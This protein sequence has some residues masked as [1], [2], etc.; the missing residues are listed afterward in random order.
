MDDC[1]WG[2]SDHGRAVTGWENPMEGEEEV[3]GICGAS[4][5]PAER[6]DFADVQIREAADE[7]EKSGGSVCGSSKINGSQVDDEDMSIGQ[8]T[9]EVPQVGAPDTARDR[10][11][12]ADY[13]AEASL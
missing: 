4:G 8:I 1:F 10:R 6:R 2:T 11:L 12:S 9:R 5:A 7:V 3:L 13:H